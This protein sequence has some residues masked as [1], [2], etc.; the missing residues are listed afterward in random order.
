MTDRE[1]KSQQPPLKANDCCNSNLKTIWV[2]EDGKQKTDQCTVCGRNH[3]V[4][5]ADPV[6]LK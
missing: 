1:Q 2:S 4:M 3:Y 6:Q 5:K